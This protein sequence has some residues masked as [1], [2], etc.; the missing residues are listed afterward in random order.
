MWFSFS[1]SP[2]PG[3]AEAC[4]LIKAGENYFVVDSGDGNV[5]NLRNWRKFPIKNVR[6][7][8]THLHSDH[9]SDLNDLHQGPMGCSIENK[10][11]DVYGPKGVE[12]VT[13]GVFKKLLK[14]IINLETSI[15]VM[16]WGPLDVAGFD[17][18]PLIYPIQ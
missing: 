16:N 2:N 4:I 17:P 8:L 7:L 11:L 14:R 6:V 1:I 9:I 3:R 15:T 18:T 10:K 5:A 13:K 12:N